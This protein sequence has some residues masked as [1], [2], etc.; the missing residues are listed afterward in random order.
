MTLPHH[1]NLEEKERE[2][3]FHAVSTGLGSPN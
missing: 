1:A 3:L 2:L